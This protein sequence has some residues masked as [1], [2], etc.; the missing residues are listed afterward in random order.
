[1]RKFHVLTGTLLLVGL[2]GCG[3]DPNEEV[4][5]ETISIL[6]D[7]TSIINNVKDILTKEIEAAKKDEGKSLD[8]AKLTDAK[9][10]AEEL[11]NKAKKLAEIKAKTEMLREGL[12]KEQREKL[13]EKHKDDFQDAANQLGLA[14]RNLEK[15][16]LEAE[17]LAKRSSTT[18]QAQKAM[19]VLR[20]T[21][22][23]SQKEFAVMNK[24]QT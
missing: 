11:K 23:N 4:V 6:R 21:L 9:N 20:E 19:E 16:L 3:R 7:T 10:A 2:C 18:P 13:A 12:T 8:A 17:Q 24:K 22:V 15:T 5:A 14:E 1:M